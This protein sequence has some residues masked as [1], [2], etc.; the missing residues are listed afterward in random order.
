MNLL[1]QPKLTP[2]ATMAAPPAM[3]SIESWNPAVPPPPVSGAAVGGEW[4]W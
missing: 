1:R 4:W 3:S 2:P